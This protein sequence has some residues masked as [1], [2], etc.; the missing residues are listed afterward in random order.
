MIG[1]VSKN[2][3]NHVV[4]AMVGFL[5]EEDNRMDLKMLTSS[6][7]RRTALFTML[8][9][10]QSLGVVEVLCTLSAAQARLVKPLLFAGFSGGKAFDKEIVLTYDLT[11]AAAACA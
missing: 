11:P 6:T 9:L 1:V 7:T 5:S 10:A 3:F 2:E 8:N 4:G